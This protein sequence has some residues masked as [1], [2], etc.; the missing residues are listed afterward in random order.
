MA[1]AAKNVKMNA[2][3]LSLM[4]R[5]GRVINI[6]KPVLKVKIIGQM[7]TKGLNTIAFGRMMT[8]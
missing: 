3:N 7:F 2:A 6:E 1:Y 5:L 4:N 8:G